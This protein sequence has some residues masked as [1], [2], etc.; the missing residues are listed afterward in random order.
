MEA[1]TARAP[2]QREEALKKANRI[3]LARAARK[4]RIR[5]LPLPAA[6]REVRELIVDPPQDYEAMYLA[7]LLRALPLWGPAKI[8]R[9]LT[10]HRIS[11]SKTLG[12]LTE[13]QRNELANGL[14]PTA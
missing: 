2:M 8:N 4:R 14:G 5:R 3:R 1:A 7:D 13:R 9:L 12:G 11:H 6:L 10:R